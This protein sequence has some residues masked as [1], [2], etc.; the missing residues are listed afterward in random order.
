MVDGDYQFEFEFPSF[1]KLGALRRREGFEEFH[2]ANPQVY[3]VLVGLARWQRS[4]GFEHGSINFLFELCRYH[5]RLQRRREGEAKPGEYYLNN[6]HRAGY[7]RLIM[8]R[9][10]DLAG[11]FETRTCRLDYARAMV[12]SKIG[13]G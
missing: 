1:P 9:E 7:A 6:N 11:F 10:P 12:G 8:E 2:R 5:Y 13:Q 3:E 4:N